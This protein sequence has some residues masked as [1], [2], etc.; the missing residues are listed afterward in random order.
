LGEDLYLSALA[1]LHRPLLVNPRM[2]VR[3]YQSPI[4]RDRA[5]QVFYT[6]LVNHY[7]L[8][9]ARGAPGHRRVA[10]IFTAG[11]LLAMFAVKW[12]LDCA[13]PGKTPDNGRLRGSGRGFCTW[14]GSKGA[15]RHVGGS[16]D[17]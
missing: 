17:G 7:H 15:R 13:T 4:S 10:L 2:R 5:E 11:G 1:R 9:V 16:G 14:G 6:Q 3:H 8:L 12:L